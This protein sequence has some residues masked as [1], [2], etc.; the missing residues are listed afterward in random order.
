MATASRSPWL[1]S[2]RDELELETGK[3]GTL[4][5]EG[6]KGRCGWRASVPPSGIAERDFPSSPSS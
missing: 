3:N 6:R 1:A 4:Q 5:G 2:E